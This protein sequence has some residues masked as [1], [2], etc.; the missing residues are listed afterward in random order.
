[1]ADRPLLVTS[2]LPYANGP[3]HFGHIAGA[4]LPADV[5][6]RF[7]RLRRGLGMEPR[8]DADPGV[9]YICGTDEHGVAITVNAEKEGQSYQEYVDRWYG[10]IKALFERFEIAFDHFSRTSNRH[11]HYP[12]SQEFF[13]RLMRAGHLRRQDVQQL[14]SPKA[15]RFLADRYVRG[16]CY[17]CGH[18][19]A[20]GDECPA[21]GAWLDATKLLDPVNAADPSERLELR[22]AWQFELDLSPISAGGEAYGQTFVDYLRQMREGSQLGPRVKPNVRTMMFDKLIDGEGLRGRPI[23][24]DLPWGVPL[25]E[26]DLD[27]QSLGDVSEKVLYVWFDAPIGYVSA[28]IEWARDVLGEP[29]AWRR[30]WI[31]P[32]GAQ[33]DATTEMIHFIGKD[34]IPFHCIVFPAMLAGQDPA[35]PGEEFLGPREGERFVLP[36]NVPANEFYNLEGRKFSTSERWVLDN[37]RMFER[38]GVDALRWYLTRSMPETADS[39]FTFSG[40]QGEVN[41]LADVLGNYASRVLKF[42]RSRFDGKVPEPDRAWRF[43]REVVDAESGEKATEERCWLEELESRRRA[44]LDR[45][46]TNLTLFR[47]RQASDAVIDLAR[48]GNVAFDAQAP[49]TLRKTDPSA[50]ASSLHGHVQLLATLSVLMAPFMPGK[51]AALRAM[52]ALP[53]VAAW[54]PTGLPEGEGLPG[55]PAPDELP[56]GH[57]LGEPVILFAK[58]P[59]D[60]VEEE[61]AAL[62]AQ[63]AE[64]G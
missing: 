58:I 54:T 5:Y 63:A 46:E 27:G 44:D 38:Y 11:P 30:Y 51:A 37:E 52:L 33:H 10:E 2:A 29:G 13:L 21:C 64:R 19:K 23:T 55:A 4:Y 9:L 39:Q 6:V 28:T 12:L 43:S 25:P 62:A 20:R 42:V 61:R 50:C 40:L 32:A 31:A 35:R 45:A 1:M 24:R 17:L 56:P 22:T 15:G 18:E 59:D 48:Y 47:F 41:V 8:T 49:W 60:L 14:Y 3:L 26:V 57:V 34:N 36:A 53:P 16:T 7:Q